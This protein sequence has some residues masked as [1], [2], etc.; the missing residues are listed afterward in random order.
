MIS[1][2][3]NRPRAAGGFTLIEIV[4]VLAL[5]ALVTSLVLVNFDAFVD[6]GED[7]N[8]VEV[9]QS[10]VREAR[11]RAGAERI[12]TELSYDAEKGVLR[13]EPGGTEYPLNRDFGREGRGAIRFYLGAPGEGLAPVPEIARSRLETTR[14]QFAPDR[15]AS[16]FVAEI[17]SGSGTPERLVFDPFSSIVRTGE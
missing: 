3:G 5:I 16:P 8:P 12:V 13:L 4:L 2:T 10:A 11:F 14:V 7:V 9:L 15:S 17:D 1:E 6:R